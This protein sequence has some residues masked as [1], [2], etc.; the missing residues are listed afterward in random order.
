MRLELTQMGLFSLKKT[1]FMSV[2]HMK[3]S[4]GFRKPEYDVQLLLLDFCAAFLWNFMEL[5]TLWSLRKEVIWDRNDIR[6]S[7]LYQNLNCWM[8]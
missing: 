7:K 3:V 4:Y 6:V 5:V 2:T 1:S 8:N